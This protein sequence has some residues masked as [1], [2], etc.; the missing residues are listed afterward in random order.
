MTTRFNNSYPEAANGSKIV[1]NVWNDNN[2]K[3]LSDHIL[4]KSNNDHNEILY[5]QVTNQKSN[6]GH[7]YSNTQTVHKTVYQYSESKY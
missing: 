2:L 4:K 5:F 7:L 1:V 3:S 6:V